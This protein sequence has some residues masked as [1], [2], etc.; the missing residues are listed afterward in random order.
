MARSGERDAGVN[1]IDVIDPDFTTADKSLTAKGV[2]TMNALGS[3]IASTWALNNSSLK[4]WL[5]FATYDSS[6][7]YAYAGSTDRMNDSTIALL[8]GMFGNSPTT[9]PITTEL[10]D[11]TTYT[12]AA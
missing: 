4:Y 9:F 2:T 3:S 6:K 8:D 11:S 1:G 7:V 10:R 5:D 12:N